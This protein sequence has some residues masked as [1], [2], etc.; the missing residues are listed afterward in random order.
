MNKVMMVGRMVETPVLKNTQNGV[1]VTSFRIAV[2]KKSAAD[3]DAH[4][5]T[6]VAWRGLAENC[7]NFLVS[8]QRIAVSGELI[9]RNFQASDGST[10]YTTEIKADEIEFLDRPRREQE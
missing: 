1:A 3:G 5:F 8:G 2:S 9:P 7:A 6:V 10:K 4:F